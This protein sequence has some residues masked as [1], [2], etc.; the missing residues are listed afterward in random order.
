MGLQE[1]LMAIEEALWTG[2]RD[3]YTKRLDGD[4]LV[5]F[6]KTAGV[7]TREEVAAAVGEGDRWRDLKVEPEGLIQPTR[8]VALL[9][10]RAAAVRGERERYHALV[11]S[12]YVRRDG[13]WKLMF[14]HQ[15]PL[16]VDEQVGSV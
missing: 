15:T 2:G 9:T 7:S 1:E 4:C 8:D 16:P 6:T 11:S 14:H 10:Y 12:G 5:A 13:A 3:D